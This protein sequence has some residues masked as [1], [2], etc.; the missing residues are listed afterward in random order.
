MPNGDVLIATLPKNRR[1]ELRIALS[2]Y[3]GYRR[4]SVRIWA[5]DNK[6]ARPT[7][8]GFSV[9]VESGK[10]LLSAI[11]AAIKAAEELWGKEEPTS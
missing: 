11:T 2:E 3:K 7:R 8:Q 5:N 6:E 4:I 10:K 1:E 9:S